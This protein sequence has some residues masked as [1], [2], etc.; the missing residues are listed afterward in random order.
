MKLLLQLHI[1]VH[2]LIKVI[3]F[4][5]SFSKKNLSVDG[6]DKLGWVP[7]HFQFPSGF[8]DAGIQGR[9]KLVAES[10][11]QDTPE[12]QG[13]VVDTA[14]WQSPPLSGVAFSSAAETRNPKT[15][16]PRHL[17]GRAPGEF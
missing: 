9:G 10:D 11:H 6:K 15:T 5:V 2:K 12:G 8:K 14:E 4:A 17:C 16:F 1:S 13:T 3:I 7:K